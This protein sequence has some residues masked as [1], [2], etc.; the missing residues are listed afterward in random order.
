M[1]E[2]P[3]PQAGLPD[4]GLLWSALTASVDCFVVVLDRDL[5]I[6][7]LNRSDAGQPEP[8][9][10][11]GR[12]MLDFVAPEMRPTVERTIKDVF[13]SGRPASYDVAGVNPAGERGSYS[14]RASPVVEGGAVVAVVA[15]AM[16]AR[17]LHATEQALRAERHVLQQMLR[18][19]ERERQLVSYEIHDGL[20]QYQA[21]AIM[22]LETA[23]HAL[24]EVGDR[25][26]ADVVRA[27]HEGLRLLRAAAAE[28]RRLINGLRPPMLDEL[29]IED[30][31]ESLVERMDA[32]G[33][34][35][36]FLHPH[37]LDRLDPD[38]ET[39]LFRIVQEC[40]SN[41]RKHARARHVRIVLEPRGADEVSL[42]VSD[43]GIGFDVRAVAADRFGLEGIRQRARLF[44]REATIASRPGAGTRIDV[45]LPLFP[46]V[47]RGGARG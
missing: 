36:E 46:G 7:F 23:V 15:T 22:Q 26:L 45:T 9:L 33:P 4:A 19:Q 3:A 10:V 47:E 8:V 21:G 6:L 35:V 11:V 5:R 38:V 39:A 34:K 30:A 42:A 29:G 40:L 31:V 2:R 1:L 12:S 28:A 32:T 20:A 16:D 24:G 17:A 37:P 14:V 41:V 44:G 27:C 43:D 18:T 25:R 13:E